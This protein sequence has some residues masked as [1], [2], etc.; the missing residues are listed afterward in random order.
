[1]LYNG[2]VYVPGGN[3]SMDPGVYFGSPPPPFI[4]VGNLGRTKAFGDIGSHL[5]H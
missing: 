1:M 2:Q 3:G 5:F 4:P